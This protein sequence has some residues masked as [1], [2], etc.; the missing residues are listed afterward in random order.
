MTKQEISEAIMGCAQKLGR[1]PSILEVMKM[2][3]VSRRQIRAEFGSFTQALRECN[4][5]REI[6]SGQGCRW[7]N[8]LL[9]GQ[10]WYGKWE[11]H[12]A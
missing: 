8:C 3:Q 5:E 10:A 11:K 1:V 7:K 4:L 12:P 6:I 2:G 9:T